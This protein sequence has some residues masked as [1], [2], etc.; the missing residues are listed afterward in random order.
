MAAK[1][2]LSPPHRAASDIH[3]HGGALVAIN[4]QLTDVICKLNAEQVRPPLLMCDSQ[5][6]LVDD[7]PH[8]NA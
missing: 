7:I 3:G 2:E 6:R 1:V 4:S 8:P 5:L